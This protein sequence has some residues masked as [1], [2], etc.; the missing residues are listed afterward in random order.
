[1]LTC[2]KFH[3]CIMHTL[4][5]D[6]PSFVISHSHTAT[7]VLQWCWPVFIPLACITQMPCTD[8][9]SFLLWKWTRNGSGIKLMPTCFIFLAC[10]TPVWRTDCPSFVMWKC[11]RS[12]NT[13]TAWRNATGPVLRRVVILTLSVWPLLSDLCNERVLRGEG[14]RDLRKADDISRKYWDCVKGNSVPHSTKRPKIN[15][16]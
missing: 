9:A 6:C 14:G 2:S 13:A 5:T 11:P 8:S 15:K 7:V 10:I 16:V 4:G 1:M 3:A 12:S